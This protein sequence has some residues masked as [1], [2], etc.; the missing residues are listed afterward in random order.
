MLRWRLSRIQAS[1]RCQCEYG[2]VGGCVPVQRAM[3]ATGS[4]RCRL[5][6]LAQSAML[7]AKLWHVH[8]CLAHLNV[9]LHQQSTMWEGLWGAWS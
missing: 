3:L 7:H 9:E 8:A 5:C 1:D 6:Q 2:H 4:L